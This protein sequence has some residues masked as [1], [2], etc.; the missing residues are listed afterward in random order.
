MPSNLAAHLHGYCCD[1]AHSIGVQ[2]V[3]LPFFCLQEP[4]HGVLVKFF[5]LKL[6]MYVRP[7]KSLLILSFLFIKTIKG[8]LKNSKFGGKTSVTL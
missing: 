8:E 5:A 2:N 3:V 7:V 6:G 4:I 1:V